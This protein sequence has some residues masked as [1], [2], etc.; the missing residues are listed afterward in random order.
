MDDE[1]L[2]KQHLESA[3]LH[4][5]AVQYVALRLANVCCHCNMVVLHHAA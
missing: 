3:L 2:A 1:L 4:V 5:H